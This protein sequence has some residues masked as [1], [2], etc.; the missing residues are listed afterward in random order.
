MDKKGYILKDQSGNL[1]LFGNDEEAYPIG[2]N[3]IEFFKL[4][5]GDHVEFRYIES[6]Y[7][8]I[9]RVMGNKYGK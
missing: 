5:E 7:P 8:S 4:K 1:F 6:M 2:S 3:A 9:V